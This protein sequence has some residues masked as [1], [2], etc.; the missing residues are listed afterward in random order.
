M[1]RRLIVD[2]YDKNLSRARIVLFLIYWAADSVVV[3]CAPAWG[4]QYDTLLVD[5]LMA[6]CLL[7]FSD[8]LIQARYLINNTISRRILS[9]AF[10]SLII[11]AASAGLVSLVAVV[12][13]IFLTDDSRLVF[14]LVP[15]LFVGCW[16]SVWWAKK[17]RAR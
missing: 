6:N 4:Y 16:L 3:Y 14:L 13:V 10:V 11:Y 1:G 12:A 8:A 5:F 9:A 7:S 2:R 17:L 15:I